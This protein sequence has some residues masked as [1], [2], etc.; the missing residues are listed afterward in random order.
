MAT[1]VGL[2]NVLLSTGTLTVVSWA[3]RVLSHAM[4][5][6]AWSEQL[7]RQAVAVVAFFSATIRDIVLDFERALEASA[8]ATLLAT[9]DDNGNTVVKRVERSGLASSLAP[10]AAPTPPTIDLGSSQAAIWAGASNFVAMTS[11]LWATVLAV[12]CVV[13]HRLEVRS[14]NAGNIAAFMYTLYSTFMLTLADPRWMPNCC[15]LS[16][17]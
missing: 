10:P 3:A 4:S 13:V 17:S 6:V 5:E 11:L 1:P 2:A 7:R 15:R 14:L 16:S 8:A 12:R 9:V